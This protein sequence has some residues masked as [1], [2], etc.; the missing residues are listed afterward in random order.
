MQGNKHKAKVEK[1]LWKD[2]RE[3]VTKT[4]PVLAKIIDK[5]SPDKNYPLFDCYYPFGKKIVDKGTLQLPTQDG[6]VSPVDAPDVS[7][8]IKNHLS[9]RSV[10]VALVLK[11]MGEV[12]YEMPDR[13]ISLNIFNP[14]TIFGL[15]EHLDPALSHYV[16]RI[17]SV[18]SGAHSLHLAPKI[19]DAASHKELK[20]KYGLRS[21][22]PK[23][24]LDHGKIF[25]EIANSQAFDQEWNCQVLFFSDRWIESAI[26]DPAWKDFYNYLL[27]EAWDQSQYWR[28]K[29]TFDI[30]W[31]LF[32]RKIID[33][34]MRANPYFV[35][36]IKHLVLAGIGV[37]PVSAAA[38]QS[39]TVGPISGLQKV[40]IEDYKLRDYIPTFMQPHTFSL[41][42]DIPVYYSL[43][44]P[45]LLET[46]LTS[47]YAPS[48]LS[49]MPEIM[50]LMDAFRSEILQE[51]FKAENTPIEI[52]AKR[53]LCEYFHSD[54]DGSL[55]IWPTGTLPKQDK[56]LLSLPKELNHRVFAENG[57]YFRGCIRLSALKNK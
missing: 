25:A 3:S 19:T 14:G 11:N 29:V 6:K 57:H 56:R 10:P 54:A 12:F 44:M 20:K 4:T 42:D 35:A 18:S 47:R 32:T 21:N 38:D 43:Q 17:W 46:P 33:Q 39:D 8:E 45:I 23:S 37:L 41:N 49:I 24:L 36:I 51:E 40:Y 5:L 50:A 26:Q 2:V 34:N 7:R 30:I 53:V 31:E 27:Q 28:N 52:F 55:G 13:L 1:L 48:I 22:L 16:K 9:R 15:W